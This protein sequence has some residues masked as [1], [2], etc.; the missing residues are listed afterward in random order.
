MDDEIIIPQDDLYVITWETNFGEFPDSDEKVT[1]PT[2]P[3][4]A[5]TSTGLADDAST[6][7]EIFTDVDLRSTEPHEKD[8]FDLPEQT[9]SDRTY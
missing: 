8:E 3:S 5:D 1:T 2:R 7:D 9:R 4:A 6:Q